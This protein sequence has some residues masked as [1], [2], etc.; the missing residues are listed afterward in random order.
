MEN[1]AVWPC[2]VPYDQ[3]QTGKGTDHQQEVY[4]PSEESTPTSNLA[5]YAFCASHLD[6][7]SRNEKQ[8]KEY[9]VKDIGHI[10]HT[11]ARKGCQIGAVEYE[12]EETGDQKFL[13]IMDMFYFAHRK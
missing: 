4:K 9:V 13:K 10:E 1:P 12:H 5:E 3:G 2:I 7:K 8:A 6:Q 11:G